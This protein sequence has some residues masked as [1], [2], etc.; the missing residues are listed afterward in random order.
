MTQS[1]RTIWIVI[2]FVALAIGIYA[3]VFHRAANDK[4]NDPE[5]PTASGP[6]D[7]TGQS[8]RIHAVSSTANGGAS[9]T[10]EASQTTLHAHEDSA[11]VETPSSSAEDSGAFQTAAAQAYD[12]NGQVGDPPEGWKS[13]YSHWD[14]YAFLIDPETGPIPIDKV[15]IAERSVGGTGRSYR[16]TEEARQRMEAIEKERQD[17]IEKGLM[18]GEPKDGYVRRE[19][20]EGTDVVYVAESFI[21]RFDA[22]TAEY[23]AIHESSMQETTG[24]SFGGVNDMG[25]N[26]RKG[27]KVQ[28]YREA[29]GTLMRR[30]NL[31]SGEVKRFVVSPPPDLEAMGYSP[32]EIE[33]TKDQ[34]KMPHSLR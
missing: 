8:P 24:R 22:L 6:L 30:V 34:W 20:D 12:S 11:G 15:G 32:E 27:F 17:A 14:S 10:E 3:L 25:Y 1:K 13:D 4:R 7:E 9:E 33:A 23:L 28:Y 29:D 26:S 21:D 5:E 16:P 2:G 31:A 19:F 18:I